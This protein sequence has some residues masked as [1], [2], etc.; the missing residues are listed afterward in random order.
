[1]VWYK[2]RRFGRFFFF[3]WHRE[4]CILS[5]KTWSCFTCQSNHNMFK[6]HRVSKHLSY[7][8]RVF[9]KKSS[10][11]H[12]GKYKSNGSSFFTR[13][14]HKRITKHENNKMKVSNLMI[15]VFTEL[16]FADLAIMQN[17]LENITIPTFR[18]FTGFTAQILSNFNGYGCWC[19]FGSGG[20]GKGK[21]QPVDGLDSLCRMLHQGYE[22]AMIDSENGGDSACEAYDLV[23][24]PISPTM[25]DGQ[26]VTDNSNCKLKTIYKKT[27]K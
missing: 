6:T 19:Y 22:C 7:G 21:S 4:I 8:A 23:Y 12:F 25:E 10:S 15:L 5:P 16:A 24:T 26:I 3:E 14:F 11:Q 18:S 13:S 2:I 17:L 9:W 1:M 20:Y 27:C